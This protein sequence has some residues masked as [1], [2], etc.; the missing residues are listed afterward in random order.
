MIRSVLFPL[1]P[2]KE[3]QAALGA[4]LGF[5]ADW[6][7]KLVGMS[8]IDEVEIASPEPAPIGAGEFHSE[9]V[10][11]QLAEAKEQASALLLHFEKQGKKADSFHEGFLTKGDPGQEIIAES[12][13][14][15]LVYLAEKTYYKY[16]TQE[17]P[18]NTGEKVIRHTPRPAI[19]HK[20]KGQKNL[21]VFATDGSA[22]SARA[23]QMFVSLGLGQG[24]PITIIS[25]DSHKETAEKQ[26]ENSAAY[27]R[28]HGWEPE[29]RPIHSTE[30]A[31]IVI[32]DEMEHLKP[33]FTIM[34]AY[35]VSGLREFFLGSVTKK[36]VEESSHSIFIYH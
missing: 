25:V 12:Y 35:G 8:T 15:D 17:S 3:N 10:A 29:L 11:R 26:C 31:D 30:S 33:D 34:G 13:K 36:L 23:I 6:N 20:K 32:L 7:A 27:L 14:H 18:C 28:L 5:V 9:R 22:G 4:A 16:F 24:T 19:I 1:D 21:N 2:S